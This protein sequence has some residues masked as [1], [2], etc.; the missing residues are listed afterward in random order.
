[1]SNDNDMLLE[2]GFSVPRSSLNEAS[3]NMSFM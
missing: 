1:M 3:L 2:N